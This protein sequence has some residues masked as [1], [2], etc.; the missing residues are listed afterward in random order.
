MLKQ[1]LLQAF[2]LSCDP[3]EIRITVIANIGDA[4]SY[5]MPWEEADSRHITIFDR[6][7]TNEVPFRVLIAL[8]LAKDT[9]M[10][11][12]DIKDGEVPHQ[13]IALCIKEAR[14]RAKANGAAVLPHQLTLGS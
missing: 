13:V 9:L 2:T 7:L 12:R 6:D 1:T 4:V 3:G 5:Q 10:L 11:G 8:G 14:E